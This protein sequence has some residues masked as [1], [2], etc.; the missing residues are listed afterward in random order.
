VVAASTGDKVDTDKSRQLSEARAMVVREY[1]VDHFR[2]DDTRIKTL[3]LGKTQAGDTAK[4]EITVYPAKTGTAS[5]AS[6]N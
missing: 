6:Q 4:V 5:R 3:P 1:L 2:L